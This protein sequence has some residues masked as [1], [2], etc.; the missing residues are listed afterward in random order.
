MPF[1]PA[2][3]R[4]VFPAVTKRAVTAKR[5]S[6]E[7]LLNVVFDTDSVGCGC[8]DTRETGGVNVEV[9]PPAT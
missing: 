2:A 3:C 4:A 5:G 9:P 1:P 8:P 7:L 6:R